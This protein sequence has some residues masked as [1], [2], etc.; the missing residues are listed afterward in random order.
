MLTFTITGLKEINLPYKLL[1]RNL[2]TDLEILNKL[3]TTP[4]Y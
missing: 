2:T 1:I 4:F 3:V